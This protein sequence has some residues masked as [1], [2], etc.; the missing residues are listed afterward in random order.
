M[1]RITEPRTRARNAY[2][3]QN[4]YKHVRT[5]GRIGSIL[6]NDNFASCKKQI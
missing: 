2:L 6:R 3:I 5:G 4:T 1:I